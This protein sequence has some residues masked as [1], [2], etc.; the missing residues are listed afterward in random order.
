[1]QSIFAGKKAISTSHNIFRGAAMLFEVTPDI[2]KNI[3]PDALLT[4]TRYFV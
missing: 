3:N 4:K 2:K 1:M